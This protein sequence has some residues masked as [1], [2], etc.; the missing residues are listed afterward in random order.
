[1]STPYTYASELL[2]DGRG[3]L[4]EPGSAAAL[5]DGISS[6]LGDPE[7]RAAIGRR[8][9]AFSRRMIWAA[10]GEEYTSL[11]HA[12]A[13]GAPVAVPFRIGQPAHA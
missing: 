6:L 4:V 2:A 7:L 5:A 13:R 8:A 10:V 11:F 1:V 12:T 9:H 3:V